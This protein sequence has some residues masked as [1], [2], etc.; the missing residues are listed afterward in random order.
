M[1]LLEIYAPCCPEIKRY[2]MDGEMG[3][4]E[5]LLEEYRDAGRKKRDHMWLMFTDLRKDFDEIERN[6]HKNF[7]TNRITRPASS[8]LHF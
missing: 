6:A 2:W 5:D 4:I 7:S 8:A 3:S 1:G